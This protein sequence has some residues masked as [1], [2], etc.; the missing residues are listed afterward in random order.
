M[1]IVIEAQLVHFP[2]PWCPSVL[3]ICLVVVVMFPPP[4]RIPI[5]PSYPP[6]CLHPILETSVCRS[7][8]VTEVFTWF[9]KN[10]HF[11]PVALVKWLTSWGFVFRQKQAL[12]LVRGVHYPE[13]YGACLWSRLERCW[14]R[15]ARVRPKSRPEWESCASSWGSEVLLVQQDHA[16][17]KL[18]TP[19]WSE[20]L[21][22]ISPSGKVGGLSWD[23]SVVVTVGLA[24]ERSSCWK[25]KGIIL[26]SCPVGACEWSRGHR[27]VVLRPKQ[28]LN[29]WSQ[30][31]GLELWRVR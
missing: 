22:G 5:D 28:T 15:P 27:S 29:P 7:F 3:E 12:A 4:P 6:K 24:F 9:S 10:N 16:W 11:S 13:N 8:R 31:C 20:C 23:L 21:S 25:K 30:L 17:L 14:A 2:L 19:S 26:S 1:Q 18:E